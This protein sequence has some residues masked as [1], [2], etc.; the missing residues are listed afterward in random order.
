MQKRLIVNADDLGLSEK[1]N[2]GIFKAHLD[3]I[4]TC[5]TLM[6]TMPAVAH[7]LETARGTDLDIGLHV[8]L[9]WGRPMSSGPSTLLDGSG[10]FPGKKNLLKKL[11]LN[12]IRPEDLERE[13]GSQVKAF[14]ETGQP[15]FHLDVH[16]HFHG[17]PVVMKTVA[18]IAVSEGVPFLR[19]VDEFSLSR[20]VNTFIYLMFLRSRSLF[21]ARLRKTDHFLGLSL[22]DRLNSTTLPP[23]LKGVK[24]GLSE[25]MCHP[26][27][28][29][30]DLNTLSRLQSREAEIEA[31]TSGTVKDIISVSNIVLTT[32]RDEYLNSRQETLS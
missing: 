31:L 11:L 13:I 10:S 2:D 4:V 6:M 14:K 29:D 21:P 24:P 20:P 27:Y 18:A 16:Q 26:G 32:F 5:S 7:A 19:F 17:F 9:S 12:R 25:L 23:V 28:D 3:G 8:D 30:P 1:I 22:T 15:L